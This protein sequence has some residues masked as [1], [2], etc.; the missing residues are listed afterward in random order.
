M[1]DD[2]ETRD[3][4][5]TPE[6]LEALGETE[7]PP[8]DSEPPAEDEP[9]EESEEAGEPSEPPEEPEK[10]D[11][12]EDVPDESQEPESPR[13]FTQDDVERIIQ[14]RLSRH[15][16]ELQERIQQLEERQPQ[17][18]PPQ[19]QEVP[20]ERK[21]LGEVFQDPAWRG[22]SLEALEKHAEESGDYRYLN[23][24]HGRLG[25][26]IQTRAVMAEQ[27]QRRKSEEENRKR[28]E[29]FERGVEQLRTIDPEAF[30]PDGKPKEE[31]LQA[32]LQHGEKRGIY[33]V[34]AAYR[35]MHFDTLVKKAV[36]KALAEYVQKATSDTSPRR[37]VDKETVATGD[38]SGMDDQRLLT[39]YT[40][41]GL[42]LEQEAK[43]E[44]ILE[45]R[46]VM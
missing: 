16:R 4:D 24:A 17:Q 9:E 3:D 42:T 38:F 36:D 15:Q 27:E 7:T 37:M 26:V 25:A 2:Q 30:M 8:E 44:K 19:Q 21:D 46:G 12:T 34:V 35:D 29:E 43:V 5:F 18:P 40:D 31:I 33:D 45:Q 10:K 32:I 14:D 1:P 28:E 11:E 20:I 22:W 39:L 13:T 23:Q 6:E 41:G